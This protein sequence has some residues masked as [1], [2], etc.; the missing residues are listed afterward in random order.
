MI[1]QTSTTA[2]AWY[3]ILK[4][5]YPERTRWKDILA[6]LRRV[7]RAERVP[8]GESR[9]ARLPDHGDHVP[10]DQLRRR[11]RRVR[12][13]EDL[14]HRR[15]RLHV[16]LPLPHRRRLV[17]H[18]VQL[19]ARALARHDHRLRRRHPHDRAARAQYWPKVVEWWDKA[20]EG[21]AILGRPGAFFGRVFLPSF[22]S[23]CAGLAVVGV[24]LNA[25]GI[26]VSFDTL[27]HVAGGN[28][29]ANVTSVTPGGVGVTQAWN[30]A[31]LQGVATSQQAT[32][33]SIAQQL[34]STAWS[35]LFALILMIWAWG[36]GGGK[37]L[38]TDSYAEAKRRQQEEAD[39]RR[40]KKEARRG[41]EGRRVSAAYGEAPR[42]TPERPSFSAGQ[43]VLAWLL[44]AVSLFVAALLVPGATVSSFGVALVGRSGHRRSERRPAAA[45]RRAAASVHGAA[46]LLR[47][48]VRRR[49]DVAPRRPG[50]HRLFDRLVLVGARRR[51][52]CVRRRRRPLDPLRHERRRHLLAPR[53]RA[54]RPPLRRPGR[55]RPAGNRLPRDR[56]ARASGAAARDARRARADAWRAGSPTARTSCSSGSPT[57][58][59]RRARRRRGSCS[60][61]TTT[62]P[63][64]AGSRRSGR[65][66]SPARRRRT[67]RSSSGGTRRVRGCS[68]VVARAAATSSPAERITSSSPSAAWRPSA[69]PTPATARSSPT[70]ST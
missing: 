33:Y 20:K 7:G 56:R 22:I 62:S 51:P 1:V 21:G 70:G 24:F 47:D 11:P 68:R 3:A 63:P 35:I 34:V 59:R 14:L 17:R 49:R 4:F 45:R 46:R 40:A 16:P 48:P 5:A 29:L 10:R 61:R 50:E 23:W 13:R 54:G 12:R 26:P 38:V 8:P 66:S 36:W 37:K 31:S 18:L 25:Y 6:G 19:G 57:S 15:R 53:R 65:C 67:A 32:A 42:W 60:A 44:G 58:P 39:K 28:S 43:L 9:H 27:M 52:R 55:D 2:Y 30:V 69:R 64:S 41:R